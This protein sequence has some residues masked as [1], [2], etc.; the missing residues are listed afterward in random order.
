MPITQHFC[1]VFLCIMLTGNI[2]LLAA[3]PAS[4]EV[5]PESELGQDSNWEEALNTKHALLQAKHTDKQA[6][7]KA[8]RDAI[9]KLQPDPMVLTGA[10]TRRRRLTKADKAKAAKAAA[11]T[12][13]RRIT[14]ADKAKAA[15]AKEEAKKKAAE[16]AAT[17]VRRSKRLMEKEAAAAKK[18]AKEAEEAAKEKAAEAIASAKKH[19]AVAK[20]AKES[21]DKFVKG[22]I[23]LQV[24][25]RSNAGSSNEISIRY[26]QKIAGKEDVASAW[27][28][29]GK[30]WKNGE[31]RTVPALLPKSEPE[32]IQLKTNGKDGLLLSEITM[33]IDG[34]D[35]SFSPGGQ[36]LMCRSTGSGIST[37]LLALHKFEKA[38]GHGA[39]CV[40]PINPPLPK[41]LTSSFE[42]PLP[43]SADI[44][45]ANA[46]LKY[47]AFSLWMDCAKRSAYRFEYFA[48]KDCGNLP[49]HGGFQLDPSFPKSCQQKN[50]RAYPKTDRGDGTVVA[51]DRG[52]LVPANHLD[53]D[54][55]AIKQ[56]NYMTNILP[57][58]AFMNR[59]A[60]LASEE[61][62]ECWRET[63]ALHVLGGAVWGF[64]PIDKMTFSSR[65]AWFEKSHY[66]PYPTYFWKVVTARTLFPEDNHRIAWL[67]PN[68]EDGKRSQLESYVVT[69]EHLEKVLI[70]HGQ[71]QIFDVPLK[72]KKQKPLKTWPLPARCDKGR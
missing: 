52:H 3:A 51:F 41:P 63:E 30:D 61:V 60:W 31:K 18:A 28:V 15:K 2:A 53:G 5:I 14:K 16:A 43:G 64:A 40:L 38:T 65:Q 49:R 13:R 7:L 22:D 26:L 48:Y 11:A 34:K 55:L 72:Q 10:T 37:C 23:V 39:T 56:S 19:A 12:R 27:Q 68:S 4:D 46:E 50:G 47:S 35:L 25:D 33:K 8:A 17:T 59:G 66:V 62:V 57:Q 20:L 36:Y 29:L 67:F 71:P 69:L 6:Q 70:S 44:K 9:A 45:V 1:T 58:A 54:H 24:K 32:F 42:A 21:G